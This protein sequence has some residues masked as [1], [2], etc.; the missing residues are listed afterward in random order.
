MLSG[1]MLDIINP[2]P[3]D[4]E[5]EDIAHGLAFQARWNG[6]TRG[7]SIFSVAD[8]SILVWNIFNFETPKFS[9]R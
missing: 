6:Q 4:I 3:V 7:D 8:H 5:I 9:S 2:S 1:R